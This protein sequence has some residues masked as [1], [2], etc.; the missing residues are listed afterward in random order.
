[1]Y[2]MPSTKERRLAQDL[3]RMP[4]AVGICQKRSTADH[5]CL[6]VARDRLS[7]IPQA[8]PATPNVPKPIPD[9]LRLHA[10]SI[11]A[12]SMDGGEVLPGLPDLCRAFEPATGWPLSFV[13]GPTAAADGE[14][15]WSAALDLSGK[16]LQG[17]LAIGRAASETAAGSAQAA[18]R[19]GEALARLV[20][21]VLR[22]E[23]A[24]FERE[25]ELAAG[26]PVSPTEEGRRKLADRLES[27][28]QNV[29]ES[30]DCRAAGLYL[31]DAATTELKL[32]SCWGLPHSRFTEPPRPLPRALADLEA[33]AGHAIALPTRAAA[34]AWNPPEDFGAA[35]CVP[36]SSPSSILGTLWVFSEHA[37]EF[38]PRQTNLAE[39][40]AGR[41]AAE[42]E[43]EM[44]AAEARLGSGLRQDMAAAEH[45]Q[46]DQLPAIAPLLPGWDVAGWTGQACQVG[47][48]FHDWFPIGGD[49]LAVAVGDVSD[50]GL[51]AALAASGLRAALRAHA[52]HLDDSGSLLERINRSLWTGSSGGLPAALFCGVIEP[53]GG[54]IRYAWAG[55]P[56]IVHLTRDACRQLADP[57]M[58]LGI[59]PDTRYAAQVATLAPGDIL[60]LFSDGVR[61]AFAEEFQATG[62]SGAVEAVRDHRD[63][64]A[65][66]LVD[67]VRSRLEAHTVEA[68]PHDQAVVIVKRRT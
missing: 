12:P 23:R 34:A 45:F 17:R 22:A 4:P 18:A 27:L 63:A 59:D 44:L 10:D 6:R 43:L 11:S 7:T 37:R 35:L 61:A 2:E 31:L 25:A 50:H 62:V 1:M 53:H 42:L 55:Y 41:L 51:V 13:P 49:R 64:P 28:L 52:E 57:R 9:Y 32:R 21:D 15:V 20:N 16:R 33:M 46:R 26:V 19:L 66:A 65:A 24:V 68:A 8:P 54:L 48:D 60:V 36:V 30:L 58:P 47:G 67:L 39:I 38:S 3:A 14:T 56:S 29:A 5:G 40:V